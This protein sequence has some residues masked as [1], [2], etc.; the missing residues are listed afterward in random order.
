MPGPIQSPRGM[1]EEGR[2]AV[3][4]TAWK[5]VRVPVAVGSVLVGQTIHAVRRSD[6]PYFPDQDPSGTFGDPALPLLR[7]TLLGDS[8]V[9]APGCDPLDACWARRTATHLSSRFHVELISVAVGGSKVHDV[10]ANQIG[11]ALATEP[12]MVYVAVGGNDAL[13]GTLLH[14]FETDYER[15][16]AALH[17]QVDIVACSG[18]G[19]LGTIPRLPALASAAARIRARSFDKAVARVVS[20]YERAEKSVSWGPQYAGLETDLSTFAGDQF[21]A[22]AVGHGLFADHGSIPLTE[23]LLAQRQVTNARRGSA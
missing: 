12:D 3:L 10:I 1:D 17:E 5:L 9:T 11:P 16:V 6:L 4:G 14:R 20:R 8:V 7:I 13:R 15:M 19:D 22:S 18:I 21:H 23:K 2:V